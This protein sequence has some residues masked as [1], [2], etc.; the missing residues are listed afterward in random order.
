MFLS[1]NILIFRDKLRCLLR[2]YN[3]LICHRSGQ[4]VRWWIGEVVLVKRYG[5]GSQFNT[6]PFQREKNPSQ[7]AF[8][9]D[10]TMCVCLSVI[11]ICNY[12]C[13]CVRFF[14][15]MW[16]HDIWVKWCGNGR[17]HFSQ[18]FVF[19]REKKWNRK[20]IK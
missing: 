15:W 9:S 20:L 1:K 3:I 2:E 12:N 13:V 8:A 6:H 19:V 11:R 7:L 16:S 5:Q 18:L 4:C 17:H 10:V 14:T